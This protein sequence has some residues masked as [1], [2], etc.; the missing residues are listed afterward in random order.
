[1]HPQIFAQERGETR[2]PPPAARCK[3]YICCRTLG[4]RPTTHS[5]QRWR[6]RGSRSLSFVLDDARFDVADVAHVAPR[7]PRFTAGSGRE[8]DRTRVELFRSFPGDHTPKP[9]PGERASILAT[10][11]VPGSPE[12]ASC[13]IMTSLTSQH[14]LQ[15]K[16]ALRGSRPSHATPSTESSASAYFSRSRRRTSTWRRKKRW[17]ASTAH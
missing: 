11:P 17:R 15:P 4:R 6:S 12:P 5:L 9:L 3:L 1:M 10:A 13:K 8:T 14:M 7:L 16:I 2:A